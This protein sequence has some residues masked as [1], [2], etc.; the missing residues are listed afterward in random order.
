MSSAEWTE[1]PLLPAFNV[2]VVCCVL[3]PQRGRL[4]WKTASVCLVEH[5][6][7]QEEVNDEMQLKESSLNGVWPMIV[8][9]VQVV[10][11]SASLYVLV[12]LVKITNS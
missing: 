1:A 12:I 11:S 3:I 5:G 8:S 2:F 10:L 4:A 9:S 7:V 6:R